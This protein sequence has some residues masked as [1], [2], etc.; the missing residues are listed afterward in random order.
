MDRTI[1]V[2]VNGNYLTKDNKVAGVRGEANVTRLRLDFDAGWDGYAK[3]VTFRDAKGKNPTKIVLGA[4]RLE[5]MTESTGIYLCPIPGEALTEAGWCSFVIDGTASG[6]RQR[7]LGGVLEV[8]DAPE[9]TDG[10][11]PADPT[12]TQAEQLQV[13]I[14]TLLGSMQAE[15]VRAVKAAENAAAYAENASSSEENAFLHANIASTSAEN[16]R[17]DAQIAEESARQV[18][19]WADRARAEVIAVAEPT[20]SGIHN[21]I[22]TDRM[23]G[24]K[25]ALLVEGGA[26]AIL[27]VA[28]T[29]EA[30][31]MCLIDTQTGIGYEVVVDDG[32]IAIK[33]V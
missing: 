9:V 31:E 10:A 25:Y 23:T 4:D 24:A 13:Q 29:M 32:R 28:D 22:L 11:N 21:V 15:A 19:Q 17:K 14:D 27:Q 2:K 5:K 3:T 20:A 16:A 18:Q 8:K 6:K 7:S 12:P 30:T 33:E 1:E 26:L